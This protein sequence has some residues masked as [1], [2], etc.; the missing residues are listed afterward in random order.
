[1]YLEKRTLTIPTE[2]S[3]PGKN[4]QRASKVDAKMLTF[5]FTATDMSPWLAVIRQSC[6]ILC[7]IDGL[8]VEPVYTLNCVLNL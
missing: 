3:R 8:D 5:A 7:Y 4:G 6:C 2:S 1:M